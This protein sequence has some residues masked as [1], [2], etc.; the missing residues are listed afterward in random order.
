MKPDQERSLIHRPSHAPTA[1][2][3]GR[4]HILGEMVEQT[5]ALGRAEAVARTARFRIGDYTWCEPDYRQLLL[6]AEAL[7]M[8]PLTVIEKLLKF[9][10]RGER[11][12]NIAD[13][14]MLSLCWD[15]VE[16]PLSDFRFFGGIAMESLHL[17]DSMCLEEQ[18]LATIF[19]PVR[20]PVLRHYWPIVCLREITLFRPNFRNLDCGGCG[21][22]ILTVS[23]SR[24]LTKIRCAGNK[25]K[26]LTLFDLPSLS[27]LSCSGN[28]LA[29][30]DLASVPNLTELRCYINRLKG[31]DLSH[32]PSLTKLSCGKNQISEL[33]LSYVPNLTELDCDE[34][35][36]PEL[37]IRPLLSLETL[38]YDKHSTRLIQRPDQN[39]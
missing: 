39:F 37:D 24:E 18:L 11:S 4:N 32:V 13:G 17:G 30:L 22:Q 36:L 27:S 10:F 15:L 6:W 16:L 23:G 20:H 9:S 31:L 29:E 34:N 25:M 19:G 1:S 33:D 38:S 5:L 12:S 26:K 7:K 28:Q 8:E 14:R 35:P 3:I 21:I 2:V